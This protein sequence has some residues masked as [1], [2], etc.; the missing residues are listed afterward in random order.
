[1]MTISLYFYL[2]LYFLDLFG[3]LNCQPKPIIFFMS[4]WSKP[5]IYAFSFRC[6]FEIKNE[7]KFLCKI[8]FLEISII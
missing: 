6:G 5:E 1:M 8:K 3:F 2:F 4:D 7:L